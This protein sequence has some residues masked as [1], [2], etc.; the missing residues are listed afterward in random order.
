MLPARDH[1]RTHAQSKTARNA[2]SRARRSVWPGKGRAVV[3]IDGTGNDGQVYRLALSTS[4]PTK[5]YVLSDGP[6]GAP[7][8]TCFVFSWRHTCAHVEALLSSRKGR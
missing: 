4:E 6:E 2:A 5:A 7:R 8:C 1:Q 3:L